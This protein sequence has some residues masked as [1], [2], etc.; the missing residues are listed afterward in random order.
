MRHGIRILAWKQL[1]KSCTVK[2]RIKKNPDLM[3][4]FCTYLVSFMYTN[5]SVFD[6]QDRKINVQF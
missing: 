6:F 2:A 1:N 4:K 5:T 3:W